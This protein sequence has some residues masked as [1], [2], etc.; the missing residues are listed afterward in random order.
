LYGNDTPVI[1][2]RYLFNGKDVACPEMDGFLQQKRL[3]L[4]TATTN[5]FGLSYNEYFINQYFNPINLIAAS[6][7]ITIQD[8][9]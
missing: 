3:L 8:N 7:L 4:T 1:A 6:F 9:K 2:T 5:L